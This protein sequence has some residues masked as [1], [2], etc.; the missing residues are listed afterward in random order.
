MRSFRRPFAIIDIDQLFSDAFVECGG[1]DV[2]MGQLMG[3]GSGAEPHFG[4]VEVEGFAGGGEEGFDGRGGGGE[5]TGLIEG[6]EGCDG[7]VCSGSICGGLLQCHRL[8]MQCRR[9]RGCHTPR[10]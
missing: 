6:G 5:E 10:W 4:N 9:R 8:R 2:G 1:T 3:F 7:G